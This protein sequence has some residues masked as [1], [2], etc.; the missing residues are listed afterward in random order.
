MK[1]MKLGSFHDHHLFLKKV[2]V[3]PLSASVSVSTGCSCSR[4]SASSSPGRRTLLLLKR[5]IPKQSTHP[6]AKTMY[7]FGKN[8][9]TIENLFLLSIFTLTSLV[10]ALL[11]CFVSSLYIPKDQH[12]II[13]FHLQIC[14]L[15]FKVF[16]VAFPI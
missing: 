9:A 14:L 5:H 4:S 2:V 1:T 3:L 7:R 8:K 15:Q 6:N 13:I 12:N 11:V 10:L 16:A